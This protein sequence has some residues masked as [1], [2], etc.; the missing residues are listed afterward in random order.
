MPSL[1]RDD[2]RLYYELHGPAA[3][4]EQ[5]PPLVLVAGLAS[6]CRSWVLAL[7]ALAAE[8]QVLVFDNRGC[9]RSQPQDAPNSIGLMADD[10]LALADHLGFERFDLLGHSMGGFIAL[11]IARQAQRRLI[12]LVLSNSSAT[13]SARNQQLFDDWADDLD[14]G[15]S[16]ERWFRSFFFWIF[17][18]RFFDK[19]DTVNGLLD[20]VQH[21]PYAQTSTGFRAQ[22]NAMRGFDARDWLSTIETQTLILTSA[23]DLLFPPRD[24]AAGLGRLPSAE[25]LEIPRQAHSLPLE[26]PTEFTGE[27]LDFLD[28]PN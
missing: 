11:E 3:A 26:A 16:P 23:E 18:E 21:D 10:C 13:L 4:D 25:R 22:V 17:S 7:P 19:P 14:A 24:D 9:G 27:V 6:D 8:R 15:K 5:P 20:L 28:R 2:T 12:H 1:Q